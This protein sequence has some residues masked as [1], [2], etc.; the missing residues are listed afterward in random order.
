MIKSLMII[1]KNQEL[2]IRDYAL[3]DLQSIE[4]LYAKA[5]PDED[6]LPLIQDLL[7][8]TTATLSLVGTVNSQLVANAIFTNC[9]LSNTECGIALLGPV[10]VWPELQKQGFGSAIIRNGLQRLRESGVAIVSVLGDPAYYERLGFAPETQ[11]EP[12]YELPAEWQTAWQSVT[13]DNKLGSCSGKLRVPKA[14]QRQELWE[15]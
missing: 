3:G 10:A 7:L 8:E 15:A 11:I 9:V 13:L 5:F 4:R 12:P 1:A 14:W 6:L 2:E